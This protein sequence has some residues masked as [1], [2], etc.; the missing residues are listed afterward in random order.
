[1][2]KN[3]VQRSRPQMIWCMCIACWI[4]KTTYK[5]LK[6]VPLSAFHRSNGCTNVPQYYVTQFVRVVSFCD[7]RDQLWPSPPHCAGFE[8][9]HN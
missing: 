7:A 9:T 1:M 5:H 4:S 8:T 3:V 6:N 2:W